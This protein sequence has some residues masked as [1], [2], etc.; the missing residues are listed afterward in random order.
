MTCMT[1]WAAAPSRCGHKKGAHLPAQ[2][3]S[4]ASIDTLCSAETPE[5]IVLTLRPAG[6]MARSLAYGM[7][8]CIRVVL[9]FAVASMAGLLG[10]FGL[11]I[12][13]LLWFG[14]EWLY[15]LVFEL[16]PRNATP[17]KRCLGL[18]VVMASG[19]PL[20]LS[21]CTTRNLLRAADYLPVCYGFGLLSV[22]WRN[23]GKRLGDLA[24]GTLVV[25]AEPVTL[26]AA[27]PPLA[28]P[29]VPQ[30]PARVLTAQGQAAIVTWATRIARLTPERTEELACLAQ[31]V[32]LPSQTMTAFTKMTPQLLGVAHWLLGHRADSCPPEIVQTTTENQIAP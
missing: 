14:L 2:R 19:L 12:M 9:F 32:V 5:G 8:L 27:V 16:L 10:Q 26:H 6:L 31:Q 4:A 23:D 1:G 22:L 17:G 7:D 30:P 20:T 28:A 15:P 13:A 24:A 21:A 29:Q 25:F 3:A 11:G 18:R